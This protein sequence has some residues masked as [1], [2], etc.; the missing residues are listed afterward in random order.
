MIDNL[1][2]QPEEHDLFRTWDTI[3]DVPNGHIVRVSDVTLSC[4]KCGAIAMGASFLAVAGPIS[5][6][7][8]TGKVHRMFLYVDYP[9]C[10]CYPGV[11]IEQPEA[12]EN[13]HG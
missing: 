12:V 2:A 3:F 6:N 9:L 10:R 5:M 8:E 1:L 7:L 11:W 13:G 4:D